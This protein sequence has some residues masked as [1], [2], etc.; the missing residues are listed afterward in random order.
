[1]EGHFQAYRIAYRHEGDWWN[2]YLAPPETMDGAMLIATLHMG[3]AK[4][5]ELKNEFMLFM[6]KAATEITK[7]SL[8]IDPLY[9]EPHAAPEHEKAGSA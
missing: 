9:G 2:V 3:F 8:G 7:A 6:R 5:E 4:N 1:M